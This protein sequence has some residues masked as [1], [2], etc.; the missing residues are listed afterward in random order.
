MKDYDYIKKQFEE[1]GISVPESLS[2][3]AIGD[4]LPDSGAGVSVQGNDGSPA[5]RRW[6]RPLIAFAAC[7]ALVCGLFPVMKSVLPDPP[8][9]LSSQTAESDPAKKTAV[10]D[11]PADENGLH[12]FETYGE[13]KEY[14]ESRGGSDYH[15]TLDGDYQEDSAMEE[16]P[17]MVTGN[18]A[19]TM[20]EPSAAKESNSSASGHSD[21]Y[22]QVEGVDESDVV[23]TDGKYIYFVSSMENQVI[24][25][26]ASEGKARRVASVDGGSECSDVRDLYLR[27]DRLVLIGSYY[28]DYSGKISAAADR[29]STRAVIYDISD[30]S[31]P[32]EIS[33][34]GQSGTPLSTRMVGDYLYL[35]TSENSIEYT[36]KN[37]LPF[38]CFGD[39]EK[40][41]PIGNISCIPDAATLECTI[42]GSVHV[43]SGKSSEESIKARAIL[44]GSSEVYCSKDTLYVA[45]PVFESASGGVIE[46]G[47]SRTEQTRILRIAL[48]KSKVRPD[49]TQRVRGS[50]NN[51]FSMDEHGDYFRIATTSWNGERDSNN[52][53]VLDQNLKVTGKLENFAKDEHIEAVRFIADQAYVITYEQ[54]DPLFIIDLSDPKDPEIK[55][56]VKISGFSTLLVPSGEDHLLGFGFST[57]ST[58]GGVT[59]NGLKLA[60]FD[61]GNPSSPKVADSME[62]PGMESEL[63]YNH[64]ALL[65][66]P[67]AS[68]YALPYTKHSE[69]Q[70]SPTDEVV[71][72]D[73]ND[74][75]EE[76]PEL[77]DELSEDGAIQDP[78]QPEYGILAFSAGDGE[79]KVLKQI[80]T[81]ESITRCI[82]IG[83]YLYGIS[84]DDSIEGFPIPE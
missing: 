28:P 57:E 60:L 23:K 14:I 20:M 11:L 3:Q 36:D 37:R 62:F 2:R 6:K 59:T 48:N 33:S 75:A 15:V 67:T 32:K 17:D 47:W 71:V 12:Q 52:L 40:T 49:G 54:V 22:T 58:A 1:D 9:I 66:G 24:I 84:S 77:P 13:L 25:A 83:D 27:N 64:K 70:P 38:F 56:H 79:L 69:V 41:L 65:V 43:T 19:E 76:P 63:Q 35:V 51:Q 44:G 4:K 5:R 50:I 8:S 42:V 39:Q 72:E 29:A 21:T 18:S 78:Y 26:E 61:V 34:Y 68:F 30:P 45:S 55:G 82:Y 31:K 80:R 16:T 46:N 81:G 53:Y 10:S 73:G 7:A 74:L